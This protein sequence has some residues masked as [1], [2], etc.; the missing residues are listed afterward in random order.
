MYPDPSIEEFYSA[1]TAKRFE[2]VAWRGLILRE[3]CHRCS[4]TYS[5]RLRFVRRGRQR[6]LKQTVFI[7]RFCVIFNATFHSY[8]G[9]DVSMWRRSV[10]EPCNRYPVDWRQTQSCFGDLAAASMATTCLRCLHEYFSVSRCDTAKSNTS[11]R[12]IEEHRKDRLTCF[13][14]VT[15]LLVVK[16][17]LKRH[18][19]T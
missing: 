3:I 12:C 17:S 15:E 13:F 9:A 7:Q 14:I 5:W 16:L 10:E 2:G 6:I 18:F 19:L 11:H 8:Q 1:G 4:E